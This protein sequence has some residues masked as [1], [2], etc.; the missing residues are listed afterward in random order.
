M[1]EIDGKKLAQSA[2]I[3]SYIARKIDLVPKDT[4]QQYL[5][6]TM[7]ENLTDIYIGQM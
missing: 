5:A 7:T 1:V 2:A 6:D 3:M 4:Y